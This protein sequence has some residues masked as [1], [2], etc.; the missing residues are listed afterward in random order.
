M[1]VGR[2]VPGLLRRSKLTGYEGWTEPSDVRA[3]HPEGSP[4][5]LE[6]G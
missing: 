3:A 5:R 6:T 1:L 2:G 4:Y